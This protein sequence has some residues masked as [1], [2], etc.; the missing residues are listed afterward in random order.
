MAVYF[1]FWIGS[2]LFPPL[3]Y[4]SPLSLTFLPGG[5]NAL[6]VSLMIGEPVFSWLPLIV[7]VISC[8]IF[9]PVAIWR[10]NRQEF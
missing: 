1:G 9:I 4:V 3:V 2:I 6:A 8:A 10:F 5:F 7:T